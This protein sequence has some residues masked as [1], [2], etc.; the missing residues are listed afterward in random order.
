[1]SK[2]RYKVNKVPNIVNGG[3]AIPL[4]GDYFLMKGRTHET[5]GIDLGPNNKNGLEVENDEILKI[6]KNNIKIKQ[7]AKQANHKYRVLNRQ[8]IN[9]KLL[10]QFL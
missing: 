9:I 4:G 3:T 2:N 5:G 7:G 1:M 10:K 8:I 6:G